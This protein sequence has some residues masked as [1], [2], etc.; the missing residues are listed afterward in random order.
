MRIVGGKWKGRHLT[1]PGQ[2]RVR[3][4]AEQVRDAWLS[5]LAE[6][7]KGARVLDLFA[8]TGA[9][10]LEALSRGARYADFVE[11]G[12][13]SL[14][15]LKANVAALRV[16]ERTRIFKRDA[17]PFAAALPPGAYDVAFADPPYESRM[18][19]RLIEGWKAVPFAR[20][21]TVEHAESH[22][23][24]SGGQRRVME[25]G[26]AVT[27]YRAPA[28]RSAGVPVPDPTPHPPGD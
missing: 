6:E 11:N 3:P 21:L 9:L 7:L 26:T 10:G 24:P 13:G 2:G 19:D 27:T 5:A 28:V 17:L 22:A 8:G 15:A 14:H 12:P 18:L 23:L 25:E 16:R 4:T 20:V 1:S